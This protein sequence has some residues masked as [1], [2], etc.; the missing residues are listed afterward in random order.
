MGH[1]NSWKDKR[2]IQHNTHNRRAGVAKFKRNI[3][4]RKRR[5][6]D[7]KIRRQWVEERSLELDKFGR[8][9][10]NRRNNNRERAEGEMS[11]S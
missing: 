10:R 2:E 8:P 11:T 7:N 4:N 1:A 6:W 5:R 3:S 9:T